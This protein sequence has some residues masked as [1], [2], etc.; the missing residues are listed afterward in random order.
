MK[1][2]TTKKRVKWT[3]DMIAS[4]AK[5]YSTRTEFAKKGYGAYSAATRRDILDHVC[6]HMPKNIWIK[7]TFDTLKSEAL[8]YGTRNEFQKNSESAYQTA[9]QKGIL[10]Q[11][12]EHMT[13][14]SYPWTDEELQREALKYDNQRDFFNGSPKA[15]WTA[16]F[17]KKIGD[18][19]K[20]MTPLWEKRWN[21]D[22]LTE[23][24]RKYKTR[25]EFMKNNGGAYLAATRSGILDKVCSHMTSV[26]HADY[27][28][29]ELQKEA[30]KYNFKRDFI[31]NSR[32]YYYA[33][34]RRGILNQICSHMS[35]NPPSKGEINLL[36][37]IKKVYPKACSARFKKINIPNK[38]YI[39]TLEIDIYLSELHKGIEFDGK[40]WHSV[41]GLKRSHP[42]WPEEDLLNYHIIKDEYFKSKGIDIL[43]IKEEDW[44]KDKESCIKRCLVFLNNGKVRRTKWT[45]EKCKVL[46]AKFQTRS[47][48]QEEYRQAYKAA[49][50]FGILDEICS[51]MM[52]GHSLVRGENHFSSKYTDQ[53]IFDEIKKYKTKSEVYKNNHS[54]YRTAISRG[55]WEAATSHMPKHIEQTGENHPNYKWTKEKLIKEAKK[56]RTRSEFQK[57]SGSAYVAAYNKDIV[58]EICS[59]MPKRVDKSGENSPFYKLTDEEV[60]EEAQK[61]EYKIDFLR[62]SSGPY[63]VAYKRGILDDICK[64]MKLSKN[65]SQYEYSLFSEIK[66][67]YP[68][69][70]KLRVRKKGIVPSKPHVCGFDVD[71]YVPEVR[72]A[73]EFD[74][75]YW[76]SVEGLKRG[77][78]GW[79]KKDLEN[80][81]KIK[82]EYFKSKGIE[83]LHIKEEDWVKDKKVCIDRCL[84]FLSR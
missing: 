41:E 67:V 31:V 10:D 53:E 19:C 54:L 57:N 38:S 70:Q 73:I 35:T 63:Q 42:T 34:Q 14:V 39:K 84:E 25:S 28:L 9:F 71:V 37:E 2:S 16:K 29:E 62:N 27:T 6:E 51:H 22:T 33:A 59:H 82:D 52:R 66:K 65:I 36:E 77:R 13:Y 15:Y 30:L 55:L 80:Y 58:D 11:I 45:P 60:R 40:Y 8:K 69:T 79:P 83:I 7:W 49:K 74:G 12:C 64:H 47:K 76:H 20:H 56:Y 78:E 43:H 48:F 81:H 4:E 68:K 72:K 50:R 17:R 18:I 46:A 5:K 32:N 26:L 21:E 75:T 3:D 1:K 24:A 44:I 61:Y 23:E